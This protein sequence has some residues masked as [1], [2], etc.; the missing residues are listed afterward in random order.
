MR[1]ISCTTSR[2]SGRSGIMRCKCK[3]LSDRLFSSCVCVHD[4][5]HHTT[6]RS[7][8]TCIHNTAFF[9]TEHCTFRNRH[10]LYEERTAAHPM[11]LC[12]LRTAAHPMAPCSLYSTVDHRY[13]RSPHGTIFT[14]LHST[15]DHRYYRSP[16]GTIFTVLH[17]TVDHRYY[18]SP[19]DGA[20]HTE[21]P[22][23][24]SVCAERGP[25]VTCESL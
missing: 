14:V 13:Y 17:S 5:R 15:V 10:S 3:I 16:H 12:S 21:V 2:G 18:R 4:E 1:R 8:E 7:I 6:L 11:T 9:S 24:W 22:V 25:T 23:E 19:K 20:G